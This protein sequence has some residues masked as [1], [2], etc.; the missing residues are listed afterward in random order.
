M[1]HK[2]VKDTSEGRW[3][4]LPCAMNCGGRCL[5]KVYV[6]NGEIIR[7]KTD[8]THE[9]TWDNPQARACPM[10]W[11]Q[12]QKVEGAD[13]IQ[14]PLKR[15][16]WSPDNPHGELRGRDEWE[17]ISWDEA[18]DYIAAELI[19]A[20]ERYGNRSILYENIICLEGY[21]G[22]VLAPFGGYVATTSIDSMGTFQH[23]PGM[24]GF[25][26]ANNNDRM[27][28]VNADYIVLYGHNSAWGAFS[29]TYYMK[30]AHEA[31]VKFAFVGPEYNVTAAAMDAEW[32]PVRQGTDTAFLLGVAYSMIEQDEDGSII[33]WDFL[34]R[35]TVGFDADHMPADAK[36]DENF[37][38]Y[39]LGEYDGQPKTPEWASE[40]CGCPA[41]KIQ[42]YARIMSC[43][44]NVSIYA[45]GAPARNTGA[46]NFPQLLM[47]VACMGGHFGKPGNA[48]SDDQ[49]YGAFDHG[50]KSVSNGGSGHPFVFNPFALKNPVT[51]NIPSTELWDAILNGK[52]HH[53]G[54]VLLM[55]TRGEEREIDIHVIISEQNNRLQSYE[56][57]NKGVEAYRKVD[58]VCAQAIWM[59]TDARYADI[60]L[61]IATRWERQMYNFYTLVST[62]RDFA[63]A[64]EQ[65][66]EPFYEARSD[67][68][69]AIDLAERLGVDVSP[70]L[71]ITE[72]QGWFNQ[73]AGCTIIDENPAEDALEGGSDQEDALA[74]VMHNESTN[75]IKYKPLVTITQEDIDR[76][77]VQGQ[78][79]QGVIG[80]E[81][82]L[83]KGIYRLPRTEGD[84][85][86]FIAFED[87]VA[88]PEAHPL[89]TTSGKFE[90]Y[91][92]KKSDWFDDIHNCW[93]NYTPVS[94]LPKLLPTKRGYLQTF[95]N[96]DAKVKGAYPYQVSN[97]HTLRHAHTDNDNLPWL[98][99]EWA[100]PI[101]MS[102]QDAAEK[103]IESGDTVLVW[104][105]YGKI[106]RRAAVSRCIMPGTLELPHGAAPQVDE[107]TGIDIAGAD[108]TL[109]ASDEATS[110]ASNG[111]NSTLVNIEKY[112]GPIVLK[113][114]AAWSPRM[115]DGMPVSAD[116][117]FASATSAIA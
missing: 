116:E 93:P 108:N 35:C 4:S 18:L 90:I 68:D 41:E 74:A 69:V 83:Q 56:G 19:K 42:K 36:T 6:K 39:V 115:V 109:C 86:S 97:T 72:E 60:V 17:R 26:N 32:F 94:P 78:P 13:R 49:M 12:R 28:L 53:C 15:K 75:D 40:I 20:K 55:P 58:F 95:D 52:Y 101:F 10:G 103:G 117:I 38:G 14:Y 92:Q 85:I 22:A 31:G 16:H 114:D 43:K 51:D 67:Y 1:K 80:F 112:D 64:H 81:E 102:K 89:Q 106:L 30:P 33:D 65:V 84:P 45:C 79:Q 27:D 100:H 110:F 7:M 48:C 24:Y 3:F 104:N 63:L 11:A 59:K 5:T 61:P 2:T 47:T 71:A 99:E 50:P 98:R 77:G 82:F 25:K 44:N 111:W 46:E 87:F 70:F 57:F 76:Y 34:D 107:A 23:N 8:D 54:D 37:R 21:L 66:F 9:D 73:I 96:W 62:N 88:D 105:Q 29:N 113:E 91:C